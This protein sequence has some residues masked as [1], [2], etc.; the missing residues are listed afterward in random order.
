MARRSCVFGNCCGQDS[1]LV[2]RS[3]ARRE[4]KHM[5]QQPEENQNIC[6]GS[7]KRIKTNVVEG[8]PAGDTSQAATLPEARTPTRSDTHTPPQSVNDIVVVYYCRTYY[9]VTC[10]VFFFDRPV[11]LQSLLDCQP[12]SPPPNT[13]LAFSCFPRSPTCPLWDLLSRVRT[14]RTPKSG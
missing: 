2:A 13:L 11:G 3:A 6:S 12:N 14:T 4:S 7:Q 1:A 9:K 8:G 5:L 10:G